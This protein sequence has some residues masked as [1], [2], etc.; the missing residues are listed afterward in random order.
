M[1]VLSK[2]TST[3]ESAAKVNA[4]SSV[5]PMTSINASVACSKY[6]ILNLPL[7]WFSAI[8]RILQ[9]NYRKGM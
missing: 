5:D 2:V 3:T 9:K 6:L 4:S 1:V 8:N 7:V